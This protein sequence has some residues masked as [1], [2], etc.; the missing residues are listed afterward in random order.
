MRG[1]RLLATEG[2]NDKSTKRYARFDCPVVCVVKKS[3]PSEEELTSIPIMAATKLPDNQKLVIE[4]G[5]YITTHSH[6]KNDVSDGA[7]FHR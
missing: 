7:C 6:S 2:I 3:P 5:K 1:A 4:Q